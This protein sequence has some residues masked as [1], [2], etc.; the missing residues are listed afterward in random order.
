MKNL[1]DTEGRL[2]HVQRQLQQT[3]SRQ[4]Q[5]QRSGMAFDAQIKA[6][7]ELPPEAP[8][9][10]KLGRV[11]VR[12]DRPKLEGFLQ[13]KQTEA[14][15]RAKAAGSAVEHLTRQEAEARSA[16]TEVYRTV[17]RMDAGQAQAKGGAPTS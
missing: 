7:A 10:R 9:F 1:A 15:K 5:A 2:R 16:L 8:L 17:L 4:L 12:A 11:F 13:E 6:V 14:G 3:R